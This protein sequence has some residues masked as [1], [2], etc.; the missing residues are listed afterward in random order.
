MLSHQYVKEIAEENRRKWEE[1]QDFR[2]KVTVFADFEENI[3]KTA[4]N[5]QKLRAGFRCAQLY[6]P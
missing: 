2:Q 6:S 5:P 3:R 4:E 1:L